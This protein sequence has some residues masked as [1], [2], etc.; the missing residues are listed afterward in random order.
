M[1]R[2]TSILVGAVGCAVVFLAGCAKSGSGP[3]AVDPATLK[4]YAP[5]PDVAAAKEPITE[6]KVALGR[7]LYYETRLSRNQQLSCNSCHALTTYGVDNQATST[8]YKGQ[9][10][11]R[12]SPTVYNAAVHFAQFWDGRAPDVEEQAKGPVLNPVEMAMPSGNAVIAVLKSMPEY[13][14]AFKKA[15]P[16][17]KDPVTYDNMGKAIG[18]FERKLITPAR[19]DKFLKG[20]QGAL[21]AEEKAGFNTFVA[22]GCSTCHAG[23][24]LGGNM[25]QK[26]GTAKQWPD[27]SDPG[28]L[29]VTKSESDKLMFKVPSLRNV[30]KTGPYF[31]NGKVPTLNEAIVKMADYQVGKTLGPAEAQSIETWMKSLTGEIPADYIRQPELPKSTA[32]TP[33]ASES[34]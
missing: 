33:K 10:G 9:K 28:R 2:S 5:L 24:L 22:S 31:H 6:A 16:G 21:T 7:M 27:T 3:A 12:N 23:A 8:G 4:A 20:D 1:N 19:W 26:L 14:G 15:F 30:E 18:A 13:V 25:Y 29:K 32:R 17:E 11:D 34:D